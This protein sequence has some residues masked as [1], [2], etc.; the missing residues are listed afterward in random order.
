MDNG[1]GSQAMARF[2]PKIIKDYTTLETSFKVN[3]IC[4][5]ET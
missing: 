3:I 1:R 4:D 2:P 5:G